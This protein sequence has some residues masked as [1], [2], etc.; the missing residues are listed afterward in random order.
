MSTLVN[1]LNNMDNITW[2]KGY[3]G[4][5]SINTNGDVMSYKYKVA[6]QLKRNV[7]TQGYEY[8][9][10]SNGSKLKNYTI[11]KLVAST[12]IGLVQDN[13]QVNHIDGNKLNNNI[14]NLEWVTS[15]ENQKH[16]FKIG[17]QIP[18]INQT[19]YSFKN[20]NTD[21]IFIGTVSDLRKKYNIKNH[22]HFSKL[23]KG[24]IKSLYNI[25]LWNN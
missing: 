5:Y 6:K 18:K 16:A 14:S 15:S 13:M 17:K 19:I 2:I 23:I 20:K 11:H 8:Y 1:N 22:Q 9:K 21:E 3:E 12:F 4:Q 10:L 25:I 7:N 24:Q